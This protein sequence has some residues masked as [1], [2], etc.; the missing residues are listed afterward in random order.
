MAELRKAEGEWRSDKVADRTKV[1]KGLMPGVVRRPVAAGGGK[2]GG[3]GGLGVKT[4]R[5]IGSGGAGVGGEVNGREGKE[6]EGGGGG[7]GGEKGKAKSNQDFRD[8]VV[9]K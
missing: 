9:G 2:R 6:D 3:R 4:G 5:A 7:D 8:L 1:A